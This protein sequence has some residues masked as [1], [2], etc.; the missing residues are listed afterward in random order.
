MP[1]VEVDSVVL[2][3][4]PVTVDLLDL[5]VDLLVVDPSTMA[6]NLTMHLDFPV[7]LPVVPV[8]LDLAPSSHA[9][10]V[11]LAS[12]GSISSTS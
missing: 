9:V 1:A 11:N 5:R 2:P 12:N 3:V 10:L 6:V 4:V 7:V 8:T